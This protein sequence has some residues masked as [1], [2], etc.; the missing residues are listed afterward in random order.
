MGNKWLLHGRNRMKSQYKVN[1][2]IEKDARSLPV[3]RI[4]E[5]NRERGR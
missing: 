3:R 1:K 5:P 2:P 4:H